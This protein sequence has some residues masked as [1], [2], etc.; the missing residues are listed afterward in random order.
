MCNPIRNFTFGPEKFRSPWVTALPR[1]EWMN[2]QPSGYRLTLNKILAFFKSAVSRLKCKNSPITL[3]SLFKESCKFTPETGMITIIVDPHATLE[4]TRREYTPNFIINYLT[5]PTLKC[6][7]LFW[8]MTTKRNNVCAQ[9]NMMY[10]C[11][12]Y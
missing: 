10:K 8:S 5:W 3:T 12:S 1:R 4:Y 2:K 11:N 9:L 6:Y 7:R